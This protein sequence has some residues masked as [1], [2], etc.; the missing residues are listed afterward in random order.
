M[1]YDDHAIMGTVD[2]QDH[3][4]PR[5]RNSTD[6]GDP[7]TDD[8][9]CKTYQFNQQEAKLKTH[10]TLRDLNED[11]AKK[12]VW[13]RESKALLLFTGK[14]GLRRR[15]PYLPTKEVIHV[16]ADRWLSQLLGF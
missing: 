8:P 13:I 1:R 10:N 9:L 14:G 6:W 15:E 16:S 5:H 11:E 3:I 4:A 7:G 12:K 2:P